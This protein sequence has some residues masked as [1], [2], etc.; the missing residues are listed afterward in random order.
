MDINAVLGA[1]ST[2]TLHEVQSD[3]EN[4]ISEGK[5]DLQPALDAV[6]GVISEREPAEQ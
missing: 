1:L 4:A 6:N 5:T 2:D 3:L